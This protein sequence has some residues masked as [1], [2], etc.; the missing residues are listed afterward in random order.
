MEI[1]VFLIVGLFVLLGSFLMLT[2]AIAF[3]KEPDG[4]S[5]I[6]ALGPATALGLPLIITGSYIYST[7]LQGFSFSLLL[8]SIATVI[9]LVL[10]SSVGSNV[11]ARA[12]YLSGCELDPATEPNELA[13]P[14]DS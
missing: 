14:A 13:E 10:V 12:S 1:V 5:R 9:A 6:N 2:V 11:L 8:K 7:W 4:I 3:F